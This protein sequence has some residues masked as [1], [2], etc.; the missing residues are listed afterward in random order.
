MGVKLKHNGY[1]VAY[2]ALKSAADQLDEDVS[3]LH[4]YMEELNVD[5]GITSPIILLTPFNPSFDIAR[6][7]ASSFEIKVMFAV[8][9]KMEVKPEVSLK[10]YMHTWAMSIQFFYNLYLLQDQ[11]KLKVISVSKGGPLQGATDKHLTGHLYAINVSVGLNC[12][13]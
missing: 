13:E 1:E 5:N 7:F 4:G 8:A 2:N 3:F 12:C 11:T 10:N 9:E 6:G